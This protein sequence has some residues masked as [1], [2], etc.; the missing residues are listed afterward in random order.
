MNNSHNDKKRGE[1]KEREGGFNLEY[2]SRKENIN[3]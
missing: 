3:S 1:C 2:N